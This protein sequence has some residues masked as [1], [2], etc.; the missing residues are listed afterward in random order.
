[1]YELLFGRAARGMTSVLG[2]VTSGQAE[3]EQVIGASSLLG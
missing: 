1:M 2:Q 3:L